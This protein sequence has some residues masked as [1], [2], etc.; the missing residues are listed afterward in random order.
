MKKK[1]K[2]LKTIKILEEI[3]EIYEHSF[4]FFQYYKNA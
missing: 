4:S 1:I 2:D 3:M